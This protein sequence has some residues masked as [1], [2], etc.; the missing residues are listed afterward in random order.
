MDP[1]A[2]VT[3]V[4]LLVD[5]LGGITAGI[6]SGASIGSRLEDRDYTLTGPAPDPLIEGARAIHGVF[7]R[8]TGFVSDALRGDEIVNDDK[9]GDNSDHGA[10]GQE[11]DR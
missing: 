5:L 6:F 8:G 10:H 2:A 3:A 11:P 9:P 1:I 4:M 7:I